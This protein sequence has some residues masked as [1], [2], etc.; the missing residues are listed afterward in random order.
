[1]RYDPK[2]QNR[3]SREKSIGYLNQ[4]AHSFLWEFT[5]FEVCIVQAIADA[6]VT[7]DH[8]LLESIL[9][10]WREPREQLKKYA[11]GIPDKLWD[12]TVVDTE[13]KTA[14][15]IQLPC[16][17]S[18]FSSSLTTSS[19]TSS[20]NDMFVQLGAKAKHFGNRSALPPKTLSIFPRFKK[21]REPL[22]WHLWLFTPAFGWKQFNSS[23]KTQHPG[24]CSRKSRK[25]KTSK[26][27]LDNN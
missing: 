17:F 25:K 14:Y 24:T 16:F 7:F 4:K 23:T 12:D 2:L 9:G 26:Q 18:A 6:L 22:C 20:E 8:C 11:G 10:L 3:S 1:M 15:I 5:L 27:Q 21:K 19:F 13:T